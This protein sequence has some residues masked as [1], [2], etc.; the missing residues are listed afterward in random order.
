V[1]FQFLLVDEDWDEVGR[2]ETDSPDWSVGEEFVDEHGRR[3][4]IAAM[5][6]NPDPESAVV[7]TWTVEPA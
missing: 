5:V 1:S 7:G 4:A 3:F 6:P 2:F